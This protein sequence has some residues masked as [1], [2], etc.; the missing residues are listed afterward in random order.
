MKNKEKEICIIDS[1]MK[2]V[3]SDN[4]LKV[5]KNV[6]KYSVKFLNIP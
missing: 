2:D 5:F 4:V 3:L 6:F 1:L